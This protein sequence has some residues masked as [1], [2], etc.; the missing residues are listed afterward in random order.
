M[1]GLLR[2]QL[3]ALDQLLDIG[4]VVG[5]PFQTAVPQPIEPA[6]T[7]PD[8]GKILLEH[9]KRHDRAAAQLAVL[10]ALEQRLVAAGQG[11]V[12]RLQQLARAAGRR[13]RPSSPMIRLL[14]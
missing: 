11:L 2:H 13:T 1:A 10:G 6:V 3:A 7:R 14:A 4:V 8:H 12:D 5:Q 9:Q